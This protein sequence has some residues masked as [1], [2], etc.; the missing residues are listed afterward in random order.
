MNIYA[1]STAQW[2]SAGV[3]LDISTDLPMGETATIQITPQDRRQ[4]TLALRRPYWAGNSFSVKINGNLFKTFAP[5][6]ARFGR[7][8][9]PRSPGPHVRTGRP[10]HGGGSPANLQL[11]EASCREAKQKKL[12]AA[13]VAFA[14][15]GEMQAERD[16]NQ[17]G[18]GS[19]PVRA[20]NRNG[21]SATKWF[22]YDLPVDPAHPMTLIVTYSNDNRG[23]GA[24]DVLVD[25]KKIGD[26][27]GQRR[28]PEK[29]IQFFD[30][31]YPVAPESIAGKSKITVRFEATNANSTPSVF[32]VRTVRS[33]IER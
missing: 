1:P 24:C 5:A 22:S 23:S 3:K 6:G 30:I 18:E 27:A 19:S 21:R 20:E 12:E 29:Q 9:G 10:R 28:S 8:P 31:E 26:Q 17:Q 14:Q 16:T 13:T 2:N 32:G 7:R 4:F 15:P 11:V 33:D 25:A